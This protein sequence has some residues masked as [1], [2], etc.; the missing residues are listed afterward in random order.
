MDNPKPAHL[1]M[2]TCEM[3]PTLHLLCKDIK[4]MLFLKKNKALL[5]I[6]TFESSQKV[7]LN[8]MASFM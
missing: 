4:K 6:N 8:P 3:P 5:S 7:T 2:P 1:T